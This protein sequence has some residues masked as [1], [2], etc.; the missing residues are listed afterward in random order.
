MSNGLLH[1]V[2]IDVDYFLFFGLPES[3]DQDRRNQLKLRAWRL[4]FAG[5][6]ILSGRIS[7][8]FN[9]AGALT[10]P[11]GFYDLWH[12]RG[13][14]ISFRR[15]HRPGV[16]IRKPRQHLEINCGHAFLLDRLRL[17]G[18]IPDHAAPGAAVRKNAEE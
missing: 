13:L 2:A 15:F 4:A 18:T 17:Q 12:G 14:G 11:Q 6:K 3:E 9:P 5:G 7:A 1:R 16:K 10:A 8:E